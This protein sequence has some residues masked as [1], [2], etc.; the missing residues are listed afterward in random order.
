MSNRRMRTGLVVASVVG[1]V[2]A[3]APA[4]SGLAQGNNSISTG[5]NWVETACSDCHQIG[6]E[7]R[8]PRSGV[9]SFPEIAALPSTTALSIRAFLQSDHGRM[10]NYQLARDQIDD[11]VA[12]IL[13]L[14]K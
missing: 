4:A 7:D 3:L 1:S 12:Y 11:V 14:K 10:P 5:R 9:P 6:R 8:K 2:F 13:S